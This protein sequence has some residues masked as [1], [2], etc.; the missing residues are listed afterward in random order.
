[1]C[2]VETRKI[3]LSFT[4]LLRSHEGDDNENIKTTTL[5]VHHDT[6]SPPPH[7]SCPPPPP[8]HFYY[9]HSSF[10]IPTRQA[11]Q[12]N[13]RPER[14][15][16]NNLSSSKT[17]GEVKTIEM[18]CRWWWWRRRENNRNVVVMEGNNRNMV[19]VV[20]EEGKNVVVIVYSFTI[21]QAVLKK[22]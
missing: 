10:C 15:N 16:S 2:L 20:V 13:L 19:V 3:S 11:K 9:F 17:I 22:S 5:H 1:M 4:G 6:T 14:S 8:P 21:H 7:F 18:W 12:A